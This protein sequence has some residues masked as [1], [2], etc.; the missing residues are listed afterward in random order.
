MREN[1]KDGPEITSHTQQCEVP[2]EL[3]P[4]EIPAY[5]E[6]KAWSAPYNEDYLD[7]IEHPKRP[8]PLS[9]DEG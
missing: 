1:T 8:W 2:V 9:S 3:T 4:C 6:Q 5:A 7:S